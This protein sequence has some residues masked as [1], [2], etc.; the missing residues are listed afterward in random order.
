MPRSLLLIE[1]DDT[2]REL[3]AL[4]LTAEGWQVI[5]ASNGDAALQHAA[6]VDVVLSDLQMPGLCGTPLAAAL[7]RAADSRQ[8]VLLAMTATAT[9]AA[10]E[11][12]DS[13]LLKPFPPEAVRQRCEDLLENR[14]TQAAQPDGGQHNEPVLDSET[15]ARLRKSMTP[16]QFQTLYQFALDDAASRAARMHAAA[17]ANDGDTFRREA[18]A[19][20]GSAGMIGARRLRSLAA[21]AEANGLPTGFETDL[22]HDSSTESSGYR[23]LQVEIAKI[24]PMLERLSHEAV[25]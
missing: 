7:R 22:P 13:L 20:K 5:E 23:Q 16:D 17:E 18:H 8:P 11:G 25:E 21:E 10:P 1:D 2:T 6:A 14:H 4:L 24:R 15:C 3:L 12:F 19:L 9:A